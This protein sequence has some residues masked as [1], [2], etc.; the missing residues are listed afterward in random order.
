[1][2]ERTFSR[3]PFSRLLFFLANAAAILVVIFSVGVAAAALPRYWKNFRNANTS[4]ERAYHAAQ[5]TQYWSYL[6]TLL[7]IFVCSVWNGAMEWWPTISWIVLLDPAMSH[8]DSV[9]LDIWLGLATAIAAHL[10][11]FLLGR[12]TPFDGQYRPPDKVAAAEHIAE[13][14]DRYRDLQQQ[15]PALD[16]SFGD[17]PEVLRRRYLQAYQERLAEMES[18]VRDV[19]RLYHRNSPV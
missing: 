6:Y 18:R 12:E 3:A 8:S 11:G 2:D 7:L 14:L 17:M 10:S 9:A 19:H 15:D 1:V 16:P 5:F 13:V 4:L